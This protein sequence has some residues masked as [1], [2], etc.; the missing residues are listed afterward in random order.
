MNSQGGEY[1]GLFPPQDMNYYVSVTLPDFSGSSTATSRLSYFANDNSLSISGGC[2]SDVEQFDF[3][4]TGGTAT[5]N[6]NLTIQFTLNNDGAFRVHSGSFNGTNAPSSCRMWGPSVDAFLAFD[7]GG[8]QPNGQSGALPA[9][10]YSLEITSNTFSDLFFFSGLAADASYSL[11]LEII[12]FGACAGDFNNDSFVD[13]ADFPV[14]VVAYNLL[15]CADPAMTPGCPAD[16]NDDA[17]VDDSDF[18]IFVVAY[19]NLVCP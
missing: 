8:S 13:D 5:S 14:F 17:V 16:L 19:N 15:D 10:G 2:S 12:E 3:Y 18:Q 11:D 1:S 7:S 4:M 9:G 6:S